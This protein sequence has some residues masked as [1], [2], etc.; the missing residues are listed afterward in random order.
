[1]TTRDTRLDG[2]PFGDW[3]VAI[4]LPKD[5]E[6][7]QEHREQLA[8]MA[9][10]NVVRMFA[11]TEDLFHGSAALSQAIFTSKDIDPRLREILMLRIAHLLNCAYEWQ[12]NVA[13]GRN[14]G[15]TDDQ[16][17]LLR[18]DG[19]VTELDAVSNLICHVTDEITL[20][21]EVSDEALSQLI[22]LY[23]PR[24]ASKYILTISWFNLLGSFLLSTRV[25]L[26][27][28]AAALASRTSPFEP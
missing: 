20:H 2:P 11:G 10:I 15:L 24:I 9:P 8:R 14:V 7:S 27:T 19:P 5:E 1:M 13:F 6:L 3:K 25:P 21:H 12:A 17:A 16:I 26:E 23:G 4:P 28:D 18:N 22:A